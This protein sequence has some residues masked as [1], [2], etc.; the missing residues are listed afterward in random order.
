MSDAE[1]SRWQTRSYATAIAAGLAY[2]LCF[3]ILA[4]V[5]SLKNLLGVMSLGF[6]F[7]LPIG[8]GFVTTALAERE[9]RRSWTFAIFAPVPTAMSC[10]FAA[11]IIGWEGLIC[12][13]LATPV[14][15][16]CAMIGG[17]LGRVVMRSI[18]GGARV[19]VASVVLLAPGTS[20]LIE[21]T[22]PPPRELRHADTQIL[23]HATPDVVWQN[24]IRVPAIT[25]PLGGVFYRMGFPKPIEATL[26]YEGV[27]GIRNARFEKNLTFIETIDEWQPLERLSF[28]IAV[29]PAH[30]PTT[31][32]DEHVTVGG[33]F[34]DVMRGTYWLE[35]KGSDVVLHLQSEFRLSTDFNAYAGAWGAFLMRDIQSSIL[36]VLK[37]RCER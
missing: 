36:D 25:E 30:T 17:V 6:V 32:L 9:A 21:S 13:I 7:L 29:D 18:G 5:A 27:G 8:V 19:I 28:R 4:R 22:R 24:I 23:I 1:T 35:P 15:L 10:L 34:F 2:G 3:Q 31:T 33:V 14:Y 20:A 37:Q 16:V 26:S 12:L 11:M